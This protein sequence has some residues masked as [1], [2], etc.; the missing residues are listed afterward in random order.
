MSSH[1]F[2]NF[3]NAS[4]RPGL[5]LVTSRRV[6]VEQ[7]TFEVPKYSPG[8]VEEGKDTL[9]CVRGVAWAFGIQAVFVIVIAGVWALFHLAR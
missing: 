8:E 9:G 6:A 2:P 5:H 7:L 1:I 3:E 4:T